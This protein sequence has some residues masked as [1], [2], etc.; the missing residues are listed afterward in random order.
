MKYY[1]KEIIK[2]MIDSTIYKHLNKYVI[3][4]IVDNKKYDIETIVDEIVRD[5][6]DEQEIIDPKYR[7]LLKD[8]IYNEI[9]S[10]YQTII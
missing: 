5:L 1:S 3:K 9:N 6:I 10:N 7:E 2:Q 4:E 8:L